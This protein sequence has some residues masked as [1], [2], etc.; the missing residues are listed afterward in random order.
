MLEQKIFRKWN[1]APEK[2]QYISNHSFY[3]TAKGFQDFHFP[4]CKNVV[5]LLSRSESCSHI[6]QLMSLHQH[7]VMLS[8]QLKFSSLPIQHSQSGSLVADLLHV[9]PFSQSNLKLMFFGRFP[10]PH[11]LK[12]TLWQS[13]WGCDL[14]CVTLPVC[15]VGC[16]FCGLC[17]ICLLGH[18]SNIFM[19]VLLLWNA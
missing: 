1:R 12:D 15:W 10:L 16:H 2:Y 18:I 9:I 4:D 17:G 7:S 11:P 5:T 3:K 14:T 19:P 8:I 13:T 6:T